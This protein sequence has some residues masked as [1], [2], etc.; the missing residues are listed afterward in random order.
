MGNNA[1]SIS[2][3]SSPIYVPSTASATPTPAA[4]VATSPTLDVPLTFGAL[5]DQA[6]ETYEEFWAHFHT[7]TLSATNLPSALQS[8]RIL[9]SH[10]NSTQPELGWLT[11]TQTAAGNTTADRENVPP[12]LYATTTETSHPPVASRMRRKRR[13]T[14]PAIGERKKKSIKR[15]QKSRAADT[16]PG[17]LPDPNVNPWASSSSRPHADS[18]TRQYPRPTFIPLAPSSL[19]INQTPY[20]FHTRPSSFATSFFHRPNDSGS[21]PTPH[22]GSGSSSTPAPSRLSRATPGP[23]QSPT[24]T[25]T[26]PS[27]SLASRGSEAASASIPMNVDWPEDSQEAREI[28]ESSLLVPPRGQ[29]VSME[30]GSLPSSG[31]VSDSR[32]RLRDILS[33]PRSLD[34]SPRTSRRSTA[35]DVAEDGEINRLRYGRDRQGLGWRG[36]EYFGHDEGLE[37]YTLPPIESSGWQEREAEYS[38]SS[39]AGGETTLR[40]SYVRSGGRSPDDREARTPRGLARKDADARRASYVSRTPYSRRASPAPRAQRGPNQHARQSPTAPPTPSNRIHS[41]DIFDVGDDDNLPEAVRRGGVAIEGDDERPTPIS[42]DGDPEVHRHDPEAHLRG[43]SD[44]WVQEVWADP[45]GTSIT[46]NTFN[47]R[48]TRSYGANRRAASDLRRSITHI[49]GESNFLVIAPD[50]A[51]DYRGRG[52]VEWAVTGLTREGVARL[53]R[54]RVWSFKYISFFPRRR[55]LEL[56]RWLL[57][58]EGFLDDNVAN[59][60]RA[61]RSTFERPQVRQRIEQMIRANPEYS[62][63][64]TAEA[65]RRI[66]ATLRVTVYTLDNETVVANIYL[67]SPTQSVK[68]WRRWIQEL[69]ELTFGSY[70]TAIARVRRVSSCAGCLGVDHPSHL[71]PFPRMAGWNGPEAAGGSAYSADG[72]ELR[73]RQTTTGPPPSSSDHPPQRR[74]RY[75][76]P[77]G[78]ESAQAGPSRAGNSHGAREW[79][80]QELEHG[81]ER[82]RDRGRDGDNVRGRGGPQRRARK[83]ASRQPWGGRDSYRK[84]GRR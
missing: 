35:E 66:M 13:A 79:D 44:D 70:R 74:Q 23:Q 30:S 39:R 24:H 67:R 12:G 34:N 5:E 6:A 11:S 10:V 82:G 68:V 60:E 20:D 81:R 19:P 54:R 16:A 40:T 76:P 31:T 36:G 9:T 71:C 73:G 4:V 28:L 56:P 46:L 57:A 55:V 22:R 78:Q 2:A 41:L 51:A 63:V 33:D 27:P 77:Y 32:R 50:Q 37:G 53:L 58:V 48:F 18:S 1:T 43:L 15:K 14:S 3:A 26:L 45:S 21:Y 29:D 80:N 42:R 59:I 25:T 69:R 49:T 47:P 72:R 75:Q 17:F 84:D 61:I 64:P 52:P 7:P 83:D 38:W 62:R 65:F 8:P